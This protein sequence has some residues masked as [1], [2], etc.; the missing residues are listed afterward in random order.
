[1]ELD[2]PIGERYG[3]I[4]PPQ[5]FAAL[6]DMAPL[7]SFE[8]DPLRPGQVVLEETWVR[9]NI[10][11][12]WIPLLGQRHVHKLMAGPLYAAFAEIANSPYADCIK[13]RQCGIFNPRRIG[14]KEGNPLSF[15]AIALGIDIN[16]N[17]N[18]FG[19]TKTAIR[20][21]YVWV[22]QVMGKYGFY[23]GGSW[24]TPDDM[25]FQYAHQ[26]IRLPRK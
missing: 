26:R 8:S 16:W 1:M 20:R 12:V 24:K 3:M 7:P 17:E 25:H 23:W 6:I 18:P 10:V 13:P 11:P 15:H 5:T 14:W 21:D 4:P 22:V 19:T 9:E 2:N